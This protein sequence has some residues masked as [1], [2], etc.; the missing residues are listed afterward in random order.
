PHPPTTVPAW[1]SM[2]ASRDPGALGFY[3]F[4]NRKDH[5]YDGYAF[6]NSAQVKVPR[7]WD[8]LGKAGLQCVVLGVP[9][10]YPPSP[11]H[12]EMVTC[13]LTPSTKSAYTHPPT[14]KAALAL[15]NRGLPQGRT[16]YPLR[17]RQSRLP[18]SRGAGGRRDAQPLPVR[19]ADARQ[20][21]SRRE[22][23][24]WGHLLQRVVAE[25]RV[26][27]THHLAHQA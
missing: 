24:G 14:L 21:R 17:I 2:M 7:L 8:W 25:R 3:G 13:F 4:R 9:Q 19:E 23:D 27:D 20:L 12:G 11:I 15:G 5:S 6:A 22:E 26:P 10:T 16:R 1:T 18:P